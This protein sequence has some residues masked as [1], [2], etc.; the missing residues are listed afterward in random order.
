[1]YLKDVVVLYSICYLHHAVAALSQS[2]TNKCLNQF[3]LEGAANRVVLCLIVDR[4][5]HPEGEAAALYF[6]ALLFTVF[7]FAILLNKFF[8]LQVALII[9]ILARGMLAEV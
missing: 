4:R 3:P 2:K 5:P 6:P 1:V 7:L 9:R 8:R